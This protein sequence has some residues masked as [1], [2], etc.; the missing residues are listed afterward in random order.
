MPSRTHD[1][2]D[3]QLHLVLGT[4]LSFFDCWILCINKKQQKLRLEISAANVRFYNVTIP[5]P[6]L[7]PM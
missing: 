3:R 6:Y 1:D 7:Y 2:I 4:V 5:I